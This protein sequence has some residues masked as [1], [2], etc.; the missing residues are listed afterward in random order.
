MT[1][2]WTDERKQLIEWLKLLSVSTGELIT[3][4]SG[5]V[6]S[7]YVDVKKT[8]QH[9]DCMELLATLLCWKI[10]QE[11]GMIDCVCGVVLGGCHLASIVAMEHCHPINV[12]F[13][14]QSI[15]DHGTQQLVERPAY[16]G[17]GERCV[18]LEDVITT[19][20]SALNAAK[21]LETVGYDVKGIMTVVDRREIKDDYMSL[22][23]GD[24]DIR[25]VGLVN[26]EEL[27]A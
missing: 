22:Q 19:G 26:F 18:L 2:N 13:V 12:A 20:Q 8:A 21:Q 14:R 23:H 9:R 11:F 27:T 6:S 15:K 25:V 3:L 5:Q 17:Q 16:S 24:R 1:N 4:A 7:V 10:D